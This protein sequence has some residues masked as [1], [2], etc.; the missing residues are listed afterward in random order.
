MMKKKYKVCT[1]CKEEKSIDSYIKQGFY[2]HPMCNPCRL[3]YSKKYNKKLGNL[4][5]QK[6][7]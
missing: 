3:S 7:W 5:N 4:K 1:S 2:Y 6:L